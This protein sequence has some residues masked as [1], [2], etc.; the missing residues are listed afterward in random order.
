MKSTHLKHINIDI[1]KTLFEKINCI[2]KYEKYRI[3]SNLIIKNV[4]T[5]KLEQLIS[6]YKIKVKSY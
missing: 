4:F 1:L 6:S 3:Y 5:N 2:L